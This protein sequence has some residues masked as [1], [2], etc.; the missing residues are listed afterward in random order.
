MRE[1]TNLKLTQFDGTD[2][3]NWLDHYNSDNLKIDTAVGE[4]AVKNTEFSNTNENLQKQI[5]NNRN[6]IDENT[7]DIANTKKDVADIKKGS[8]TTLDDIDKKFVVSD[9][10]IE[11]LKTQVGSSDFSNIGTSITESLGNTEI[12]NNASIS[13]DLKKLH[14]ENDTLD[15]DV[16]Q[17][18]SDLNRLS[19][20][21]EI[22]SVFSASVSEH[23]LTANSKTSLSKLKFDVENDGLYL[24]ILNSFPFTSTSGFVASYIDVRTNNAVKNLSS[25]E[26][27][28]KNVKNKITTCGISNSA[29]CALHS[30]DYVIGAF[31]TNIESEPINATIDVIKLGGL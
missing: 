31:Y 16:S 9:S 8:S 5:T 26:I 12:E 15:A 19:D 7:Q 2:V 22:K 1:T 17:L 18:K 28:P 25:S 20:R 13:E 27:E 24:I 30:G 10:Q 21:V 4:Q 3:P 23:T 6:Q 11:V 29:I 14:G